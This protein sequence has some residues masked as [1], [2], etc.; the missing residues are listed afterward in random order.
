MNKTGIKEFNISPQKENG[1][2]VL[3]VCAFYRIM[4]LCFKQIRHRGWELVVEL[5]RML[6][7]VEQDRVGTSV[8]GGNL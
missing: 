4:E 5:S 3:G 7:G 2:S 8:C 6:C 1:P